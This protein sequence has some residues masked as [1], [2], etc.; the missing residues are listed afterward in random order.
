MARGAEPQCARANLGSP[1]PATPS[2]RRGAA[3]RTAIKAPA[4]KKQLPKT[5]AGSASVPRAARSS[6]G[7][8]LAV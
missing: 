7:A 2:A 1:R 4:A 6:P 3:P 8:M 5:R